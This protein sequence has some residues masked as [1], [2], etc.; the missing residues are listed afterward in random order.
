MSDEP[1]LS[2]SGRVSTLGKPT[3]ATPLST[4]HPT[5]ALRWRGGVLE[6]AFV[7]T[8]IDQHPSGLKVLGGSGIEWRAVPT[9]EQ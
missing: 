6:Q 7:L 2:G 4:E 9:V 5:M 1:S 8:Q 3:L